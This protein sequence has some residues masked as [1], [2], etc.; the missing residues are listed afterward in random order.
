MSAPDS[1]LFRNKYRIPSARLAGW[2]YTASGMYFVTICTKNRIPWF[3]EIRNGYVCLSD[4]GSIAW[5]CWQEIPQHFPRVTLDGFIVMPN[6]VH[7][8]LYLGESFVGAVDGVETPYIASLPASP[9]MVSLSTI[10]G[11]YKAAVRRWCTKNGYPE[12]VWQ[13]R[14]YDHISRHPDAT[15]RIQRYIRENPQQWHEDDFHT[16]SSVVGRAPNP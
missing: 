6:H 5:R 3:G 13:A 12:F 4:I 15:V 8:L 7:C 1:I 14:F 9:D 16:S 10:M 11:T 2:D